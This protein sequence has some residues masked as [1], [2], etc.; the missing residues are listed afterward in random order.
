[1]VCKC[2]KKV[3]KPTFTEQLKKIIKHYKKVGYEMDNMQ[4]SACL[5]VNPIMVHSYGFL[6]NCM[7]VG[8][9]TM[10]WSFSYKISYKIVPL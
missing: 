2:N 1:M 6:L 10:E 3:G 5:V 9:A 8:Q 4:Q 7:M